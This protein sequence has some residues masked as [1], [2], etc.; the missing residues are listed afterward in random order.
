M[1]MRDNKFFK[2]PFPRGL[3]KISLLRDFIEFVENNHKHLLYNKDSQKDKDLDII[4]IQYRYE[5]SLY[6]ITSPLS[7]S[8]FITVNNTNSVALAYKFIIKNEKISQI[9]IASTYLRDFLEIEI[10]DIKDIL[11][12]HKIPYNE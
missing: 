7:I 9:S 5:G 4:D 6:D 12:K 1:F 3:E 2:S 11:D 8:I 10:K